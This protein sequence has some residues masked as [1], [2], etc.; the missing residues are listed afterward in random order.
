MKK[1]INIK[2]KILTSYIYMVFYKCECCS[3][4]T[5]LKSNYERHIKTKKHLRCIQMYPK[6]IQMYPKCIQMYPKKI[7]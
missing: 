5:K 4:Q 1:N 7:I 2:N 3:F 6:C